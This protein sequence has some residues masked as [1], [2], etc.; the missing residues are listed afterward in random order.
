MLYDQ[1]PEGTDLRDTLRGLGVVTDAALD[2]LAER[3][4]ELWEDMARRWCDDPNDAEDPWFQMRSDL[5][6]AVSR[7]WAEM[8]RSLH[9]E[10]RFLNRQALT[11]LDEVFEDLHDGRASN[12]NSVVVV[13]GP[14]LPISRLIR[15]RVFQTEDALENALTHPARFLGTPAPGVG[16]AGRM[17]AKGQPAFYGATTEKTALAEV[18]P[19]VGAWATT[20]TFVITRPVKLLDLSELADVQ[21]DRMLSLFDPASLV[22]AQRRDFLRTLASRLVQPVMPERQDHDYLITQVIADYLANHKH[23]AFDGILYPSVQVER[24]DA[25][26]GRNVVLFPRASGVAGATEPFKAGVDLWAYEEDGPGRW[27]DPVISLPSPPA[28]ETPGE[29]F[30]RLVASPTL[31]PFGSPALALDFEQVKVHQIKSV[32][33]ETVARQ[34][35]LQRHG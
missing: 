16:Q 9:E 21:L 26:S 23:G 22:K 19:P 1:T 11:I 13:A 8:E 3:T 2:D 28:P 35:K 5:H 4:T 15:A 17:N 24:T 25:E 32:V 29:L 27:L 31:A 18:R 14:G 20:A 30:D 33:V 12:G 10:A 6:W 7:R 34:T